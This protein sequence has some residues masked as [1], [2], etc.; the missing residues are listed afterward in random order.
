[1]RDE[2]TFVE[3]FFVFGSPDFDNNDKS[4]SAQISAEYYQQCRIY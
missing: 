2:N 4:V 1:M 3:L